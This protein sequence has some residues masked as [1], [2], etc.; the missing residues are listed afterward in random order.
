MNLNQQP[1]KVAFIGGGINSAIGYTH[2][3]AIRLD[4]KFELIAGCFSKNKEINYKSASKYGVPIENCYC[5]WNRMI[6]SVKDKVDCI[7]LLTPIPSHKDIICSLLK[8]KLPIITEK[9]LAASSDEC[10]EIM[11][12]AKENNSFISVI[13]NY[14]GYPLLKEIAA[15]FKR[16]DFGELLQI[17]IEMPQEGYIRKNT[18]NKK[19]TPQEWR[20]Y[21]YE[22]P[23]I[24]LDLGTHLHYIIDTIIENVKPISVYATQNNY[25]NIEGIFDNVNSLIK[26]ENNLSVNLWYGKIALG[27]RNGLKL[28]IFGN[29]GGA[30]WCQEIPE[31]IYQ[32]DVYGNKTSLDIGSPNLIK[33][34]NPL[35]NR[36]KPGHPCGFIE[37]FAN[38]YLDIY[39]NLM[40]F[41][42]KRTLV[43]SNKQLQNAYNALKLLEAINNSHKSN[44]VIKM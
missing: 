17:N 24:S 35:Y 33:A 5:N 43:Y 38:T 9:S 42:R 1:L 4:G 21:D 22:V 14:N 7:I 36:F 34:N 32:T 41:Y 28:R 39:E 29:K 44:T 3:S 37:A 10:L 26:Y 13:Q 27:Y 31:I 23:T 8:Y 12:L 20:M 18:N 15:R 30:E 19:I 11:R 40:L 6:E 2:L 25:G 16:G